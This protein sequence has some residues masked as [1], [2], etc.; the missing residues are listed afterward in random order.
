[1][2]SESR[3]L[4]GAGVLVNGYSAV[5]RLGA[6]RW[7]AM[8]GARDLTAGRWPL[9]VVDIGTAMTVDFIDGAGRHQGGYIV[10]GPTLAA[11]SLLVG[12][13]GIA[14][15]AGRRTPATAPG[16]N[17]GRSW[18]RS[19]L[20]A[21]EHGCAEACAAM[22]LRCHAAARQR[23]GR[24][25]RLVLTGGAA[26]AVIRALPPAV[27]HAPELVLRGLHAWDAASLC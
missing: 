6:D 22:V 24:G 12:T 27:L 26:P 14:R 25:A 3:T 5:W 20:P 18:P 16:R 19:T 7:A 13:R 8:L 15:R 2:R 11:L 17:D 4:L 1:L 9:C 23:F 21:I 10:P